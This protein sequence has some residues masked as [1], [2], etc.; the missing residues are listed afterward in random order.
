MHDNGR[1][2]TRTRNSRVI[3]TTMAFATLTVCGP[4]YAFTISFD[5]GGGRLLSTP[6]PFGTWLGVAILQVSPNLTAFT[7][8]FPA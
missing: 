4:E 6:F 1:T 8:G 2:E 7:Y 3:V 5:L